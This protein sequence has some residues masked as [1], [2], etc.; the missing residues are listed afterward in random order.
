MDRPLPLDPQV[1]AHS[2]GGHEVPYVCFPGQRE[3]SRWARPGLVGVAHIQH[4]FIP[5]RMQGEA[6]VN[7]KVEPQD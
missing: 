6:I 5:Q 3:L 7:R 1:W 4:M 2:H